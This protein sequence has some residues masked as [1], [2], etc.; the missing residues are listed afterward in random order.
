M[1]KTVIARIVGLTKL[2][3][4]WD[5]FE[6]CGPGDFLQMHDTKQRQIFIADDAI[7]S[8]GVLVAFALA[9]GATI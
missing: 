4:S 1:G 7:G 8:W 9:I 6:C 3:E 5:C 2:A